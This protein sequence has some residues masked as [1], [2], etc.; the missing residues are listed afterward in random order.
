MLINNSE[1]NKTHYKWQIYQQNMQKFKSF[2][3]WE[4]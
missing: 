2:K 4:A 1:N 3:D